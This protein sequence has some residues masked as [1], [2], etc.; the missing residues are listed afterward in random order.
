MYA[1]WAE[2]WGPRDP[3]RLC[4]AAPE[5]QRV[6]VKWNLGG[7][8]MACDKV[9]IGIEC[10]SDPKGKKKKDRSVLKV[11]LSQPGK[12]PGQSSGGVRMEG[13]PLS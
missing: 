2:E 5:K 7:G 4:S 9:Y 8:I 11:W 12:N 10:R 3:G 6:A 13:E 1:P